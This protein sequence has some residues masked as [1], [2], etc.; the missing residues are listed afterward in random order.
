MISSAFIGESSGNDVE[1][2]TFIMRGFSRSDHSNGLIVGAV[3]FGGGSQPGRSLKSMSLLKTGPPT[4]MFLAVFAAKRTGG[5]NAR[6]EQREGVLVGKFSGLVNFPIVDE[7]FSRLLGCLP[8]GCE[9]LS[10]IASCCFGDIGNVA[11]A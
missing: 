8:T 7:I 2:L 3:S 10:L 11:L 9:M 1:V 4:V 6:D 5:F